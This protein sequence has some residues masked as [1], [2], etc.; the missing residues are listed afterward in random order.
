MILYGPSSRNGKSATVDT[1]NKMMG[2]YGGVANPETF[3][4]RAYANGSGHN[5]GL[6]QLAGTRFVSVPEV[7]GNM[8]LS[9]SLV[10]RCT[11]D[12]LITTRAI[13]EKQ[14]SF[15]PQ[16]KLFMHTNHLPRIYDL[17]MFDSGRVKVIPFTHFFEEHDRNPNMV[18]ELTTEENLS[19]IFNWALGG[20][21][22]LESIGFD[23]PQSVLD[24][25]GVYRQDSDRV[26]NFINEMME[27]STENVS[28][29]VVFGVYKTWCENSGLRAG[30]EQDFKKEMERHGISVGRPR[31]NGKQVTS[32][33]GWVLTQP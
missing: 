31:V 18:A 25:I 7:E 10:K 26:G 33:L 15:V 30:R 12:G 14:F 3:A 1:I 20:L 13:Y 4:Q 16:F 28:T 5:D 8:T 11:G 21:Q 23:A 27:Q 2:D 24:A 6:A 19:G 17:S 9:S 29:T 22:K 32:Y